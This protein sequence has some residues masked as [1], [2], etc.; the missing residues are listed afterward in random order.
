MRMTPAVLLYG[1]RGFSLVHVDD[2]Y[3]KYVTKNNLHKI[4]AG[5]QIR[6]NIYFPCRKDKFWLGIGNANLH[7]K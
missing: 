2:F 7:F 6:I 1:I 4:Y 5:I 3:F